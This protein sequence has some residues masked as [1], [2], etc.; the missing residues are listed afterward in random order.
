MNEPDETCRRIYKEM[1]SHYDA[2]LHDS[3]RLGFKILYGPPISKAD[4]LFVGYQPGG[5]IE[6]YN[7]ELTNNA[8]EAWP[9]T[10]EYAYETWPLAKRMRE[11][12]GAELLKRC[13][14]INAI[15]I[16]SPNIECYKKS[17]SL[18]VRKKIEEFCLPRVAQVI[19][20]I[21]PQKIVF[22]GFDA[23]RLFEK[24]QTDLIGTKNRTL[25]LVG[26]VAR[27]DAIATLHL[28]GAQIANADRASIKKRILAF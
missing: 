27:Q 6:D 20:A 13:V 5:G 8:H 21:K 7:R 1:K 22:V 19:T 16:R 9:A 3:C 18:D 4:I 17:I 28:S 26:R 23:L 15:F 11:M 24:G 25:T 14:A 10:C 2:D 12:F